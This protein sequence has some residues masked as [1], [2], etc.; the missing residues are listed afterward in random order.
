MNPDVIVLAAARA[1]GA[2]VA[3]PD[4]PK[5]APSVFELEEQVRAT[6]GS[7][8]DRLDQYKAALIERNEALESGTEAVVAALTQLKEASAA[9]L[10]AADVALLLDQLA[11]GLTGRI[12]NIEAQLGELTTQMLKLVAGQAK[13]LAALNAPVVPE[14][15]DSGR[16]VLARRI[17]GK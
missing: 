11:T 12:G 13:L 2:R 1:R 15:D 7:L 4:A 3:V 6:L 14:Y 9:P 5:A 8:A 10:T 17:Q 16:V